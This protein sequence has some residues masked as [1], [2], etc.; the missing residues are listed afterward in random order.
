MLISVRFWFC[1]LLDQYNQ[2]S[3][4]VISNLNQVTILFCNFKRQAFY[5][6]GRPEGTCGP[7]LVCC[8]KPVRPQ[9]PNPAFNQLNQCGVRHT[10]G[11]NGRIKNPVYIEGDSEFG[12]Y[13]W[14]VAILKKD[15]KESVYVCG[16]TLIDHLYII[17]A[18]H[19]V[20]R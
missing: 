15:P 14:Q 20:K 6:G 11:I 1:L 10:H 19:C 8:R 12:E 2:T 7:R 9:I 3:S 16:G 4:Q 5:P 17:T 13:P 18:A